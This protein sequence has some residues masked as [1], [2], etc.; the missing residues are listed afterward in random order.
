MYTAMYSYGH[1]FVDIQ[2]EYKFLDKRTITVIFL[3]SLYYSL[4]GCCPVIKTSSNRWQ[5]YYFKNVIHLLL[6]FQWKLPLSSNATLFLF[7][8][9]LHSY[10]ILTCTRER[11]FQYQVFGWLFS[12]TY[13]ITQNVHFH[14]LHCKFL[15]HTTDH[16]RN[17]WSKLSTDCAMTNYLC[18]V[19]RVE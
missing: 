17:Q 10:A 12:N 14:L 1:L 4:L 8:H 19:S 7:Y 18:I 16:D 2:V 11:S 9:H 13:P 15:H 6:L 5:H 3:H